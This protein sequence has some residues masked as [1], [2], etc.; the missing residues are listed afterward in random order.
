MKNYIK[1]IIVSFV[2]AIVTI[3]AAYGGYSIYA[4]DTSADFDKFYEFKNISNSEGFS[5]LKSQ[6]HSDINDYFNYKFAQLAEL[7]D[8]EEKF[9]DHKD[10]KAP[11]SETNL[12]ENCKTNV[13]TYC[14]AI[15]ATD[16]YI[17]YLEKLNAMKGT[18]PTVTQA[19]GSVKAIVDLVK[20]RGDEID[21]D[22]KDAKI[23]LEAT[24]N[25][26]KEFQSAYPMHKK[27]REIID[28]LTK[29]KIV[30]GKIREK[31][32]SFPSRFVDATSDKCP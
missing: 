32:D 29:Y 13:S 7:I 9:Y 10:F 20:T 27:Y 14:V 15:G 30:L 18:M 31:T 11:E 21:K 28:S 1:H 26:Y 6:Y 24:L 16:I 19:G 2:A 3:F 5:T 22:A 25:V 23:V 17:A 8:K 12:V 4:A